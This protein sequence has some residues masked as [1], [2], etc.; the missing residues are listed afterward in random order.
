M[1]KHKGSVLTDPVGRSYADYVIVPT[2]YAQNLRA[3][4]RYLMKTGSYSG[5]VKGLRAS[6]SESL[7]HHAR[8]GF[9]SGRRRRGKGC[10]VVRA[11]TT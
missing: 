11:A 6:V 10:D 3:V 2:A 4:V 9:S 8:K 7:N 1:G 5:A